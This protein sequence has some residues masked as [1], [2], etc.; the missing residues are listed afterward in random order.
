[1]K[2]DSADNY[3]PYP[4]ADSYHWQVIAASVTGTFHEKKGQV[5]QDSYRWAVPDEEILVAAIADGAGSALFGDVGAYVSAE[6][7]VKTVCPQTTLIKPSMDDDVIRILLKMAF[8]EA[9]RALEMEAFA[10][11]VTSREL[12]TTLILIIATPDLLSVAQIGDG[13]TVAANKE[14]IISTITMPQ[15]G[16]Y[17][18]ET[19]FLSSPEALDTMQISIIRE[20]VA[21]I[22]AFSDGLQNLAL[23][24]NEGIPHEPFFLPLFRFISNMDDQKEAEKQLSGFLSSSRVKERTDDDLTLL[25]ATL[26]ES[27]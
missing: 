18:N 9:L 19:T 3:R 14:G 2:P 16:E 25:L 4:L 26:R 23:K 11:E 1:M 15:K 12:A 7:A 6:A 24:M 17:V 5:C 22:A 8:D 10:M 20:R 27:L 13:A 21:Y